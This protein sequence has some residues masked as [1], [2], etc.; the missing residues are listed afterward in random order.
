VGRDQPHPRA[1]DVEPPLIL[2]PGRPRD[3]QPG[4]VAIEDGATIAVYAFGITDARVRVRVM[5][6]PEKLRVRRDDA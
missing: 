6:N 1:A 4:L 3:G 2:T 5:R